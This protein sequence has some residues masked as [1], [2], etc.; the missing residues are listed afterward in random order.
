MTSRR[1]KIRRRALELLREGEAPYWSRAME[2][3]AREVN[4]AAAGRDIREARTP[5]GETDLEDARERLFST[6]TP[7]PDVSEHTIEEAAERLF[8]GAR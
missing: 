2:Q 4:Q 7:R 1:A 6:P 5:V 3:A 8:G